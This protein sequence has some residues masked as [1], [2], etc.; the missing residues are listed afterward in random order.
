MGAKL[1]NV[2]RLASVE[3]LKEQLLD[4]WCSSEDR[5]CKVLASLTVFVCLFFA[6][7][8]NNPIIPLGQKIQRALVTMQQQ[9]TCITPFVHFF[10]VM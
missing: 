2:S 10:A 4:K 7:V 8:S 6:K 1:R 9:C 3:D 5:Y